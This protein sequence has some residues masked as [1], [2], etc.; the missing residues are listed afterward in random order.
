MKIAVDFGG[1]CSVAG[2]YEERDEDRVEMIN[3]PRCVETIGQLKRLGHKVI[4]VSFCG[5]RR[6]VATRDYLETKMSG[7]FDQLYFVKNRDYKKSICARYGV[8]V[9]IDDNVDILRTLEAPTV[10]ILFTYEKPET[11]DDSMVIAKSWDHVPI[12]LSILQQQQQQQRN[13]E[14]FGI[15]IDKM[16]Y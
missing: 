12:L 2:E 4:L 7:L 11:R 5:R 14:N 9:L 3:V 10:G 13:T 6:A 15:N 8:D 16:C 1:V